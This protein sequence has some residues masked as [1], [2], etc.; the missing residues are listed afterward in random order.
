[1]LRLAPAGAWFLAAALLACSTPPAPTPT[2]VSEKPLATVPTPSTPI[3][4]PFINPNKEP[5]PPRS[6]PQ[7]P[8]AELA[9]TLAKAAAERQIDSKVEAAL[10]LRACAN[11]VP[12]S[13]RCEGE[14]AALL[15]ETP[16][17]KYE[18]EYY[19][20]QAI[21]ADEPDLDAAYYRHLGEALQLKGMYDDAATAFT[22]MIERSK[23]TA[24]AADHFL[25]AT[26][27]QGVPSRIAEASDRLHMAYEL[28][29]SQHA[30]LRDE[31]ILLGQQPDKVEQAIAR[32]EEFRSKI[33]DPAL[34]ADTE[35]RI[36]ELRPA[37][38]P[39]PTEAPTK[40][41]GKTPG[42]RPKRKPTG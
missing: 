9:A 4:T 5:P 42:P 12:Q 15:A 40:A 19:L 35:R 29:P 20:K 36:A 21:A 27:L 14:L 31:A 3:P 17:H 7:L 11:K 16:R 25:L 30:W 33:T 38:T 23:P 41:P 39:P 28:D 10:T 37:I 13:V 26:V 8:A 22:R 24:T 18:A 1:M 2:K 32:F 34:I 6:E